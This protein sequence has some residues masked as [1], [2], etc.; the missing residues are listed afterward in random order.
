MRRPCASCRLC[1]ITGAA[2]PPPPLPPPPSR[3]PKRRR[4]GGRRRR[5][6]RRRDGAAR[7]AVDCARPFM[8][9]SVSVGSHLARH[10]LRPLHATY[11]GVRRR[12]RGARADGGAG[13]GGA[14][15][16]SP[17]LRAACRR[18]RA[19]DADPLPATGGRTNTRRPSRRSRRAR[20][21]GAVPPDARLPACVL[22]PSVARDAAGLVPC[23]PVSRLGPA[24]LRHPLPGGGGGRW[25][26]SPTAERK[27][28]E[29]RLVRFLMSSNRAEMPHMRMPSAQRPPPPTLSSTH[30]LAPAQFETLALPATR[31]FCCCPSHSLE[32]APRVHASP[33][34]VRGA[35]RRRRRAARR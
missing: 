5:R 12:R 34:A 10:Q 22:P 35:A 1:H 24:R 14:A 4:S 32:P 21:R 31:R 15:A 25:A 19:V 11:A 17:R 18:H 23:Q 16:G 7:L 9:P 2:G 30:A 26:G 13:G 29:S 33:R 6:R 28:S 20:G 8:S 3:R 27:V